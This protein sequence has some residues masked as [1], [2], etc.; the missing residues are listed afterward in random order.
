MEWY[1]PSVPGLLP[2]MSLVPFGDDTMCI[3]DS[4]EMAV[5]C[6]RYTNPFLGYYRVVPGDE[7]R[8]VNSAPGLYVCSRAEIAEVVHDGSMWQDEMLWP[9]VR[10]AQWSDGRRIYDD[11][12]H[13]TEPPDVPTGAPARAVIDKLK[14]QQYMLPA[15]AVKG[16][17][18]VRGGWK[19]G[20]GWPL[21]AA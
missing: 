15:L 10:N 7:P 14:R 18:T 1:S 19:K 20:A 6:W 8:P 3:A 13:I 21:R 2:G 17:A 4:H 9:L 11:G 16:L 5:A 12:G